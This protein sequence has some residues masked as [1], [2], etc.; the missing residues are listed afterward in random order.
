[1][2]DP[3]AATT[4]T[5]KLKYSWFVERRRE[6]G[7]IYW[8]NPTGTVYVGGNSMSDAVARCYRLFSGRNGFDII[9]IKR[10][11]TTAEVQS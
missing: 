9:K 3:S 5:Y 10:V 6:D 4:F 1:M 2:C 11:G 7:S 8:D